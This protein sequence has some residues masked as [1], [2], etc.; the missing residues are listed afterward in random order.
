MKLLLI[1]FI[2]IFLSNTSYSQ[3]NQI[4]TF[5]ENIKSEAQIMGNYLVKKDFDKFLIYMYPPIIKMIGGKD[6]VLE[7]LKAGL[8]NGSEL[9]GVEISNP[10]DTVLINNEIQCTLEQIVELSV[11]GGK[12]RARGT[13]IGISMNNGKKWF[14]IDA[15]EPIEKLILEYPNLSNRLVIPKAALPVFF[16]DPKQ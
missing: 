14:F 16:K 15:S 4:D 3:S 12:L 13:L 9:I 10:S 11:K 2:I 8:S 1:G 5:K 7:M 6:K